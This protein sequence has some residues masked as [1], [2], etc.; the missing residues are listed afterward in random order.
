VPWVHIRDVVDAA[1][2]AAEAPAAVGRTYIVSDRESYLFADV[3]A[4]I[5]RALQKR[6]GGVF[7]PRTV[8]AAGIGVV[9]TACRVFHREPPFTLHRL[10]SMCGERLVSIERARRELAFEPRV[11]LDEGMR[12]TV[13]WYRARSLV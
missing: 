9:E 2:L 12:E 13:A 11:G 5:A 1:L 6:R 7:I 10:E 3:V 8:A 4:V